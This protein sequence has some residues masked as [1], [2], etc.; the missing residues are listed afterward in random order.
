M[1]FLRQAWDSQKKAALGL[2]KDEIWKELAKA[3]KR[4][5]KRAERGTLT[6]KQKAGLAR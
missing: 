5:A 1:P 3:A 2:L 6:A 4:L